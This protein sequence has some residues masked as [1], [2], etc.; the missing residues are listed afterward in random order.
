MLDAGQPGHL[1]LSSIS[2]PRIEVRLFALVYVAVSKHHDGRERICAAINAARTANAAGCT[3]HGSVASRDNLDLLL[4]ALATCSGYDRFLALWPLAARTRTRTA[5]GRIGGLMAR[6]STLSGLASLVS[7]PSPLSLLSLVA[8]HSSRGGFVID[9]EPSVSLSLSVPAAAA[10]SLPLAE[11]A[12]CFMFMSSSLLT[13][14]PHINNTR[15]L[16]PPSSAHSPSAPP[17][18][19]VLNS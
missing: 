2:G 7:S 3:I 9:I 5:G 4:L 17:S 8:Q 16:Q 1:A 14:H 19:G 18:G 6:S 12:A 11:L 15:G 10:C 13:P